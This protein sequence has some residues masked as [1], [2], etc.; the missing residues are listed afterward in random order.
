VKALPHRGSDGYEVYAQGMEASAPD[1]ARMLAWVRPGTI[2]DLGC[3]TGTV[4][5]LLARAFPESRLIAVD[6]SEEML[7]RSRARFPGIEVRAGDI[8]ER[9]LDP[10]S[11]DTIVLCSIM[12][13]VFSYKG[14]DYEPVRMTLVQAQRAL[15]PGG[16][17]IIRDGVKPSQ[18]DSV[19]LTFLRPAVRAKFERF[20]REF[21]SSEIVWRPVGE[22]VQIARRDAFEFLSKYIYDTNWAHEVK[23]HFGVF[24]LEGWL[25]ELELAGFRVVHRESYLIDWL[26]VTHYEKDVAIE[27]KRDGE[28]V[29]E[30]YPHST[31]VL[32]GEKPE[33][34]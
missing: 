13:E 11:V 34:P 18:T 25:T 15:K 6:C 22:R 19:Y 8:S 23:E 27:T 16:R 12:H 20:A 1:K 7:A 4:L 31:M 29:A 10:E 30:E 26:R 21:G 14:Y 17:M 9:V 5:E 3:G 33:R 24:T 2:A 32:V 28:Y